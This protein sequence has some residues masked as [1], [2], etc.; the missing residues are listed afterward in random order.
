MAY[1]INADDCIAC[2]ACEH[3]AIFEK[4]G[5]YVIDAAKCQ[6]CGNCAEVCPNGAIHQA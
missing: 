4:D 5:V 6:D 2:G 1:V 3:G